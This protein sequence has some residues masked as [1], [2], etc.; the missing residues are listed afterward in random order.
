MSKLSLRDRLLAA[1]TEHDNSPIVTPVQLADA[2][3]LAIE[4]L[5]ETIAP[6]QQKDWM[7]KLEIRRKYNLTEYALRKIL[8]TTRIQTKTNLKSG[9]VF[10]NAAEFDKVYRSGL[11]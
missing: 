5:T 9:K 11:V 8:N 1:M 2:L 6:R 4:T 10:I 3:A 7:N